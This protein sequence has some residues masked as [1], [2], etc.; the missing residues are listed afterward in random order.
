M[1]FTKKGNFRTPPNFSSAF[2]IRLVVG[3]VGKSE[4]GKSEKK[5]RAIVVG[6]YTINC[7]R[8]DLHINEGNQTPYFIP[9]KSVCS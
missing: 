4:M 3:Q 6:S 7:V 1:A 2:L 5:C 9:G 8:I